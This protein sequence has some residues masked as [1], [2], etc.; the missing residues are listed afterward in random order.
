MPMLPYVQ[1]LQRFCYADLAIDADSP[2]EATVGAMQTAIAD[3]V[4]EELWVLPPV[5][6]QT[7]K[8]V[9][10][11]RQLAPQPVLQGQDAFTTE[12]EQPLSLDDL[13]D[14]AEV[15]EEMLEGL[16]DHD[17]EIVEDVDAGAA[18]ADAGTPDL[19]EEIL[20]YLAMEETTD[21]QRRQGVAIPDEMYAALRELRGMLLTAL[22]PVPDDA[23]ITEAQATDPV[24][25]AG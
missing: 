10:G 22:S 2:S 11:P 7:V 12:P 20:E 24:P 8:P 4:P 15:P 9:G 5:T 14:G 21:Q 1:R 16:V 19:S 3:M 6:P 23:D 17:G 18:L 25:A 13:P